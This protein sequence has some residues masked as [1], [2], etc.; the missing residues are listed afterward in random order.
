ML[1]RVI[2]SA[3]SVIFHAVMH[4]AASIVIVICTG[5]MVLMVLMGLN[6]ATVRII[7]VLIVGEER[8][9]VL[10]NIM[11]RFGYEHQIKEGVL[12]HGSSN[13]KEPVPL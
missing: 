11:K 1:T 2:H 12:G 9:V 13:H 10:V 5:F 3:L 6:W 7:V 8:S 4:I